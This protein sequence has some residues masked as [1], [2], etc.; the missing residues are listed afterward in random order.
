MKSLEQNLAKSKV[1][2]ENLSTTKFV[3]DNKSG[4]DSVSLK[5]K[6]EKVYIPLFKRNHKENAYFA[7]LDKGKSFDID[8]EVSKSKSKNTGQLTRPDLQPD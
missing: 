6:D 5:P 1:K 7:R 4:S 8:A 2:L 3:V